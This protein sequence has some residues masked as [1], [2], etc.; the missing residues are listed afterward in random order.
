MSNHKVLICRLE[1]YESPLT[2]RVFAFECVALLKAAG[3]APDCSAS[4]PRKVQNVH[5]IPAPPSRRQILLSVSKVAFL[6][7]RKSVCWDAGDSWAQPLARL[8]VQMRAGVRPNHGNV[9]RAVGSEGDVHLENVRLGK[10]LGGCD[11]W[12][13][14]HRIPGQA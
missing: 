10:P 4:M 2:P 1:R 11:S 14:S 6:Q 5:L 13:G 9:P 8:S 12:E 3:E 7:C